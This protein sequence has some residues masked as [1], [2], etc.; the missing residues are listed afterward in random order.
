MDLAAY[1]GVLRRRG[2]V[3]AVATVT[4]LVV[5]IVGTL[6]MTPQYVAATTLR[7]T[8]PRG[9]S[10]DN[11]TYD[12]LFGDRVMNTYR[13]L[14]TSD[15]VAEELAQKLGGDRTPAISVEIPANTEFFRIKAEDGDPLLAAR[16]A[17]TLA[18]LFIGHVQEQNARDE[19]NGRE[20]L[21]SQLARL[22]DELARVRASYDK[23][24]A[25]APQ[26][27]AGIAAAR[28]EVELAEQAY[29]AVAEQADRV[30]AGAA[31]GV[32]MASMVSVVQPATPPAVP[33]SP[34][35]ALNVALGGLVGFVGGSGLAFL[36]EHLDTRLYTTAQ[37]QALTE[38][39]I[40]G[41]I[42][43]VRR[44]RPGADVPSADSFHRLR[45]SLAAL[46]R[47]APLRTLAITSAGPGEG[48][49]TVVVGLAEALARSGRK[50]VV[51]DGD[52]RS[53]SV[54]GF[55]GLPNRIGLASVLRGEAMPGEVVRD[56]QIPGLGVLTSGP[57]VSEPAELLAAA[58]ATSVGLAATIE[59]LKER[60]EVVVVDTPSWAE[61]GDAL[62]VASMTDGVVFVVGRG[63]AREEPVRAALEELRGAGARP[64]GIVV[65]YAEGN[66]GRNGLGRR[67][68]RPAW[69]R[70]SLVWPVTRGRDRRF[71]AGDGWRMGLEVTVPRARGAPSARP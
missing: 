51:V 64:I 61:A 33:T 54:H 30:Q 55:L 12:T 66:D 34:N 15:A 7:I 44:H 9:G 8:T 32:S 19:E 3:I 29:D 36:F 58:P 11:V 25:Q 39:P 52:L 48:K 5:A 38:L 49:T 22:G 16:A 67:S 28:R 45:A 40:L 69:L 53:P 59:H 50:V 20:A 70:R 14:A 2:W 6:L 4:T 60:F 43:T 26:D 13:E 41:R 18:E 68:R 35:V 17:N 21:N 42:P 46:D 24:V 10:F 65:N 23:L 47:A 31:A 57:L 62:V 37:I 1:L 71:A 63:R 56:G 27:A